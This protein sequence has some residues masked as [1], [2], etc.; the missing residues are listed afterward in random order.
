MTCRITHIMFHTQTPH[1]DIDAV[2]T[3]SCSRIISSIQHKL[4]TTTPANIII[5]LYNILRA[6]KI[7]NMRNA[8]I[9][10]ILCTS[11]T[12]RINI[13]NTP[14]NSKPTSKREH[15]TW[16]RRRRR[17]RF[18]VPLTEYVA[19]IAVWYTKLCTM[20]MLM[21]GQ[22]ERLPFCVLICDGKDTGAF[23]C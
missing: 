18:I 13:V 5:K 15:T 6:R 10:L 7:R 1:R 11:I 19:Y 21:L 14:H 4:P 3:L 16:R 2:I 23:V 12:A 22:C 9:T 17:L 20:F 8:E